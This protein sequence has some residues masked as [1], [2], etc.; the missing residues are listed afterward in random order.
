MN[1][2]DFLNTLK[3]ALEKHGVSDVSDI[4]SDYREH[5]VHGLQKGHT[6][7]QIAEKLGNPEVI[8]KAY[9]TETL[10]VKV[11]SE[12]R[13]EVRTALQVIGRLLVIA[14]FNFIVLF[15]PGVVIFTFLVTGW[16]LAAAMGGA[17]LAVIGVAV[18]SGILA[19]SF[20]SSI[21][22]GSTSLGVLGLGVLAGLIMFIVTK[23][24]L[25]GL[26]NYLQWNLKFV[27]EKNRSQL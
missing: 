8:A 6:E 11:K 4:L 27:F 5:F 13:F 19:L 1:K 7:E 3:Q 9:G 26:I 25:L 12:D 14:P 23:Y 2:Q 10:I 24:I 21:A 15:I 20:W 16:A 17:A 18:R 22:V